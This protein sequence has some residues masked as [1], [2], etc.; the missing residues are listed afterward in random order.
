MN[1]K[2]NNDEHSDKS[3]QELENIFEHIKEKLSIVLND[4]TFEKKW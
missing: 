4:S 3:Y 2:I 1:F